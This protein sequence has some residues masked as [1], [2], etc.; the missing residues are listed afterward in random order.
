MLKE[1]QLQAKCVEWFR[2]HFPHYIIFAVPN[3]A[4]YKRSSYFSSIG[5]LNGVS[6]TIVVL[7]EKILFVEFKTPKGQQ[8]PEQ[9]EFQKKIESLGYSYHIIRSFDQYKDLIN[10]YTDSNDCKV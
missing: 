9:V 4:A 2:Y 6:D 7:P 10:E 8:R 1:C 3:E 5:M